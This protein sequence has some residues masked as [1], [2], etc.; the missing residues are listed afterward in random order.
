MSGSWVNG[1]F[2]QQ[3]WPSLDLI[4]TSP[5]YKD[6]D[7]YSDDLIEDFS[8]WAWDT[9]KNN[10]FLFVNF[11][12]LAE[13]K[14]RPFRMAC[15]IQE[16]GF[17]WNDTVT[18]FKNHFRPLQGKKRL[19]NTTEFI[20]I[21]SKGKPDMDRLAIGVPYKDKSNAKRW[22]AA[23]GKDLR[24]RGNCWEI[25]YETI[26]NKKAKLHN[27]RFPLALPDMCI[28]LSGLKKGIVGDP[29]GGSGTTALAAKNLN[30]DFYS[31]EI[32]KEH[33]EVGKNRI[34]S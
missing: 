15:M 31:T 14:S 30:L 3:D 1:D 6:E 12:H 19:N 11:G 24:C 33:Y 29:F 8:A 7:G 28:K 9:L 2:R 17:A 4:I 13:F 27:D 16:A 32:N 23:G 18:W 22:K 34:F 5:P 10:S 26:R 21:F 25:P 20:F